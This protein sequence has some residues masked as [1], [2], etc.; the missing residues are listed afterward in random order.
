MKTVYKYLIIYEDSLLLHGSK[1]G[2]AVRN[3]RSGDRIG[4]IYWYSCWRQYIFEPNYSTV[5]SVGCMKDIIDFI[6]QL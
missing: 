5:Y 4:S 2:Y 1:V 3:N 6:S